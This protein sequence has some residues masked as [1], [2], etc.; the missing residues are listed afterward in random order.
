MSR[1]VHEETGRVAVTVEEYAKSE[2]NGE[3]YAYWLDAEAETWGL[4]PWALI[5]GV[6]LMVDPDATH[7]D[8]WFASGKCKTVPVTTPI[9]VL[10]KHAKHFS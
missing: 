5:D 3:E 9:F 7:C 8:V 2:L 1:R 10:A 6:D 4:D